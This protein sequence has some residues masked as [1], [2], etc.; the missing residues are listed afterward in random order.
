MLLAS[1]FDGTIYVNHQMPAKNLEFIKKFKENSQNKF[2]LVTGRDLYMTK[3][4]IEEYKIPF[5][6]LICNNGTV[7][8][9]GNYQA[10]FKSSLDKEIYQQIL[11]DNILAE[12]Y[13]L[14]ISHP[15]GRYIIDDYQ[16]VKNQWYTDEIDFLTA[17]NLDGVYQV[18]TKYKSYERM[19][20]VFNKLFEKYNG[21]LTL[22]PNV[23]TIDF[24]PLNTNKAIALKYLVTLLKVNDVEVIGDGL[25]DYLMIKEFK[26]Y[27]LSHGVDR[28]K[29][30]CKKVIDNFY[31]LEKEIFN[32]KL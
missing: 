19:E 29:E 20:T 27:T 24:S 8:Y 10:I 4:V 25:N 22:H 17:L 26:G 30:V 31:D 14:T 28:V 11:M 3:L 32:E 16:D 23:D 12:S 9:D 18:D 6:Y 13:Y 21:F 5:D 1:D 2:V 15:D 7:I